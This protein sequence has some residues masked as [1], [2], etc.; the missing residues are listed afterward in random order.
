METVKDKSFLLKKN[1]RGETP[2]MQALVKYNMTMAQILC[3]KHPAMV[4]EIFFQDVLPNNQTEYVAQLLE[5]DKTLL[6]E[7]LKD[8]KATEFLEQLIEDPQLQ[9]QIFSL[10]AKEGELEIEIQANLE[11]LEQLIQIKSSIQSTADIS[12]R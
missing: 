10:R 1:E 3:S 7:I 2:L 8:Q 4:R 9:E 6:A 5:L 11:R 12:F